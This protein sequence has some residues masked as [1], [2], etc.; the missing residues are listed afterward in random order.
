[1]TTVNNTLYTTHSQLAGSS[2]DLLRR[3]PTAGGS[4]CRARSAPTPADAGMPLLGVVPAEELAA[5]PRAGLPA[6]SGS[7]Q[8]GESFLHLNHRVGSGP[9]GLRALLFVS[10]AVYGRGGQ[11]ART[12]GSGTP[13]TQSVSGSRAPSHALTPTIPGRSSADDRRDREGKIKSVYGTSRSSASQ[14][15]WLY[16]PAAV[17]LSDLPK[18]R[19]AIR[20][21]TPTR[22]D[23]QTT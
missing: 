14:T 19:P 22:L 2:T 18:S 21:V 3:F 15:T 10:S 23:R 8:S 4:G 17:D 16:R 6:P 7:E 1:M 5:E 9:L 12:S 13:S 11:D 20:S